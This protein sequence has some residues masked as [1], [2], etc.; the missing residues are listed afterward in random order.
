MSHS[1]YIAVHGDRA[2]ENRPS[3]LAQLGS[4]L[5]S[6]SN[7]SADVEAA[8]NLPCCDGSNLAPHAPE[9]H[10]RINMHQ[11]R[12]AKA[13]CNSA[14]GSFGLSLRHGS[15]AASQN[16]QL[17]LYRCQRRLQATCGCCSSSPLEAPLTVFQE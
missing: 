17:Y 12:G 16:I 5:A 11:N 8:Q 10:Q 14:V 15:M 7:S 1:G 13:F 2:L 9:E 6:N 3:F 4:V